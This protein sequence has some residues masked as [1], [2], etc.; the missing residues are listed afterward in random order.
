MG[1]ELQTTTERQV[2]SIL[3]NMLFRPYQRNVFTRFMSLQ[4]FVNVDF[5]QNLVYNKTELFRFN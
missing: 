3:A 2:F 5:D 4:R 1:N